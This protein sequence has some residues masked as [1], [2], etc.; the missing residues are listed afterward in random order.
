MFFVFINQND[1][2]EEITN[3]QECVEAGNP[4]M[5]SYPRQCRDGDKVF[6]E[7]IIGGQRDEHGCLGPAG[8]TYNETLN[9]CVRKWEQSGEVYCSL[10]SREV[11]DCIALYEPVCGYPESKEYSNSCFA[12]MNEGVNY[13]VKG[14]CMQTSDF[15]NYD[16]DCVVF[17]DVLDGHDPGGPDGDCNCGCYNKNMMPTS[18]GGDCFCAAPSNCEC[19]DGK[20]VGVWG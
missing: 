3:F 11:G 18:S 2:E 20:C 5:E 9:G 14:N 17:G 1:S 19:V 12:C 4:V 6:V 8:Y 13:W 16:S 10:E 15:C 7:E